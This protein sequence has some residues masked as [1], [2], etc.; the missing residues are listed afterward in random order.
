MNPKV[1]IGIAAVVIVAAIGVFVMNSD[2]SNPD[3]RSN[4]KEWFYDLGD[5]KLFAVDAST[6][7]P[8]EAPSGAKDADGDPG[9]V[10]A[11]VFG[12]GDCTEHFIG[13]LMKYSAEGK[14]I[15]DSGVENANREAKKFIVFRSVEDGEWVSDVS[16]EG[17]KLVR[18][19]V[20]KCPNDKKIQSC[21]PPND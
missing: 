4:T 19:A 15:M 18:A 11:Y 20:T 10:K 12:C 3:H 6:P 9:G 14:K 16:E 13:Y 7:S 5:K 2:D 17:S 1:G 21:N 8:V